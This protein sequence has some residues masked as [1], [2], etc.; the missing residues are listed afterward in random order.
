MEEMLAVLATE[1]VRRQIQRTNQLLEEQLL[2]KGSEGATHSTTLG[3]DT[4]GQITF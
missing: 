4:P 2:D 3:R 1:M